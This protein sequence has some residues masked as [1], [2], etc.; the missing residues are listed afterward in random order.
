[1]CKPVFTHT[2]FS[3]PKMSFDSVKAGGLVPSFLYNKI[4]KQTIR[5][6]NKHF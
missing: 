2:K 1:M 3:P 6:M 5:I 4:I